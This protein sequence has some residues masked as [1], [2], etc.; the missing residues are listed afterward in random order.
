MITLK[1]YVR[2]DDRDQSFVDECELTATE[3]VDAH[4]GTHEVPETIYRSAV[5]EVGA[6]LYNR[7]ISRAGLAGFDTPDTMGNPYRPALDPLTPA[8]PILRPY[9]SAGIA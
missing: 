7:R 3:L 9:L 4:V 2:A 5:L 1:D 8:Y 6:N